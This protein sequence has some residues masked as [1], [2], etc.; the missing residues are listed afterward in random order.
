MVNVRL[1]RPELVVTSQGSG[2]CIHLLNYYLGWL[3]AIR[4]W[5]SQGPSCRQLRGLVHAV[6]HARVGALVRASG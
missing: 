6:A 3:A 1:E 2:S 4:A 5:W